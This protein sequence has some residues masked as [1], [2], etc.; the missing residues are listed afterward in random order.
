MNSMDKRHQQRIAR[1]HARDSIPFSWRIG[2]TS[3]SAEELQAW[4]LG[5]AHIERWLEPP[6]GRTPS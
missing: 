6:S 5:P 3:V 2:N 1:A 4:Q